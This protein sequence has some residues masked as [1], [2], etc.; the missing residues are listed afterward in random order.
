MNNQL[1]TL[2]TELGTDQA[3][4]TYAGLGSQAGVALRLTRNV[5]DQRLQQHGNDRRHDADRRRSRAD[6][7]RQQRQR[8]STS[9]E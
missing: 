1:D 7:D 9:G 5:G 3:A 8:G 4:Q 2:S 6:A